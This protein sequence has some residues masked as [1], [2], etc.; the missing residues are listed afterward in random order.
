MLCEFSVSKIILQVPY[1][2]CILKM[3]VYIQPQIIEGH[4][5]GQFLTHFHFLCSPIGT[6]TTS[7]SCPSSS[8]AW[9]SDAVP[10]EPIWGVPRGNTVSLVTTSGV[11]GCEGDVFGVRVMCLVW[12]WCVMWEW[13]VCGVSHLS[14]TGVHR[15]VRHLGVDMFRQFFVLQVLLV[16]TCIYTHIDII[17]NFH[18]STEAICSLNLPF[19]MYVTGWLP[20]PHVIT[21]CP[22]TCNTCC[23]YMWMGSSDNHF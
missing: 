9:P 7:T 23:N 8:L 17:R 5:I 21:D 10:G 4:K 20:H 6:Q 2:V 3:F 12:R 15:D 11:E 16:S 18:R 22:S 1:A 14:R 13:C 19:Y